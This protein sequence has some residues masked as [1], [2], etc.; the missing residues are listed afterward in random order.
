MSFNHAHSPAEARANFRMVE[1]VW[2]WAPLVLAGSGIKTQS[3]FRTGRGFLGS[4]HYTL[5]LPV[6]RC[7]L[8]TVRAGI[9]LIETAAIIVVVYC[10]SWAVLP[11]VRTF[12]S[13]GFMVECAVALSV[14]AVGIYSV[15]LLL[16]TFLDEAW[17]QV[18]S[19]VLLLLL[20]RLA[21]FV[22]GNVFRSFFRTSPLTTH[23]LP[24]SAM[25]ISV[26]LAAILSA[27]AFCVVQRSEY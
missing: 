5:S 10:V 12:A 1:L 26:L 27:T 4:T 16:S 22:P 15:S 6:S 7:R 8:F 24:W 25:G 14:C 21:T 11:I 17:Q 3:P 9:G 20:A 23:A 18:G 13:F 2:M 19:M